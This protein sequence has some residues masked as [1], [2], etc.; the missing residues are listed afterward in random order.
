MPLTGCAFFFNVVQVEITI[1]AFPQSLY[2]FK[3]KNARHRLFEPIL[4]ICQI[5]P[6]S[7]KS[8]LHRLRT[9]IAHH[10]GHIVTL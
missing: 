9:T 6:C 4:G 8:K 10:V 5:I 1:H 3:N 7:L 2:F